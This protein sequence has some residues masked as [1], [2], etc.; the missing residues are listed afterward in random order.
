[1]TFAEALKLETSP[2]GELAWNVPEGWQQGRGAFG[3]LT[4]SLLA[5]AAASTIDARER[6]L[7]TLTGEIPGAVLVGPARVKVTPLRLGHGLSTLAAQVEQGADVVAHAV[8][9]FGRLRVADADAAGT[10]ATFPPFDGVAASHPTGVGAAFTSHFEYR[11]VTGKPYS[12]AAEPLVEGWV[13]LRDPGDVP[14]PVALLAMID[15]WFPAIV[16]TLKERRPFG[17]IS[18]AAHVFDRGWVPGEPLFHRARLLAS[19]QG[20]FVELRELFT[21]KGELAA[22][23]QQ[24]MAIIK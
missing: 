7:R 14:A 15:A 10:V 24:T 8:L 9:N 13:R 11:P 22:V 2:S 20:Y 19:Q 3:G 6:P 1:M 21:P 5:H 23:N 17:T 18:F 12:G 4:L 16:P